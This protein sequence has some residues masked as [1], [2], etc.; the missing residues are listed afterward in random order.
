MSRIWSDILVLGPC[1]EI[2][3][4]HHRSITNALVQ[5]SSAPQAR[6]IGIGMTPQECEDSGLRRS[7]IAGMYCTIPEQVLT[8]SGYSI[9][10]KRELLEPVYF[11]VP[12]ETQLLGT[13][14]VGICVGSRMV[15][16]IQTKEGPYRDCL[17]RAAPIPTGRSRI[18]VLGSRR[19]AAY[20]CARG[21]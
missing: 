4:L 1:T 9:E 7:P 12:I 5:M 21:T 11:D 14:P 13:V 20:A 15:A 8:A 10:S 17:N 3:T 2:E 6:Q 16:D 19:H 18:H